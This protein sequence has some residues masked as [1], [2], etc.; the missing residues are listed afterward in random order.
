ML[1]YTTFGENGSEAIQPTLIIAH[2]L[3]GAARNWRQ[4]ARQLS[5]DRRVVTVDMRNH[6]ESPQLP[7]QSYHDMAQDLA[8]VIDQIGAPVD[9]CGHSMGGKAAMAL[10]LSH[11]TLLRRLVVADIAPVAYPHSQL[12]YVRAMR[13][14]DLNAVTRRADVETQ[15]AAQGVDPGVLS[16]LS[17]SL[18]MRT[19]QWL[20]NLEVLE[21]EMPKI[22]GWPI[23]LGGAFHA[24]TLFLAGGTSDYILP[25]H[26]PK[27]RA[28]FPH[29][30]FAKLPGTGHWLHAEKP[31]EFEA[32]LR[33]FLNG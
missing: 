9:L 6:G 28:L 4:I 27:I 22:M 24:P 11:P 25:T 1:A 33:V 10:A 17:Q 23:E 26:R 14:V 21:A 30:H 18:N 31:Q 15:L 5:N 20:L 19:K 3:F 32:T 8:E 2:G 29:A 12:K 13:A 16:F 7:T